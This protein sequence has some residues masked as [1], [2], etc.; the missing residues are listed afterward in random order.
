MFQSELWIY[1][2]SL[3]SNEREYI[4]ASFETSF[5][6]CFSAWKT[7]EER[8]SEIVG[9]RFSQNFLL[10]NQ[11]VAIH[12]SVRLVDTSCMTMFYV[13]FMCV[14]LPVSFSFPVL[15]LYKTIVK[16][17]IFNYLLNEQNF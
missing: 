16:L 6:G 12:F 3:I 2:V 15:R 13:L 10:L 1:I 17:K 11:N 5:Y 8:L 14:Q 7:R 4:K 9:W